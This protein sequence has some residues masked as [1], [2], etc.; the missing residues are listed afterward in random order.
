M[1]AV[2]PQREPKRNLRTKRMKESRSYFEMDAVNFEN[3]Q[4]P[5]FKSKFK[6]Q[7][8]MSEDMKKCQNILQKLK[9]HP[10]AYPFINPVDPVAQ[11][12]PDYFE[13]VKEPID[14]SQVEQNL[15]DGVYTTQNQFTADIRKIWSNSYLYN[16]KN[17]PIYVVSTAGSKMQTPLQGSTKLKGTER[18]QEPSITIL[19]P[20]RNQNRKSRVERLASRYAHNAAY[21]SPRFFLD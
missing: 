14:L 11:K 15:R 1:P 6:G 10:A 21:V 9:K 8:I 19:S 17:S 13:I 2:A 12:C 7:P 20:S 3:P 4:P 5:V 16:Q 18:Y